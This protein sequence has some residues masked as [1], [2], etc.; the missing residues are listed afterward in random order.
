MLLGDPAGVAAGAARVVGVRLDPRA[1]R[2]CA[3]EMAARAEDSGA[4]REG[5]A[6]P[7]HVAHV[8]AAVAVAETDPQRSVLAH[9]RIDVVAVAHASIADRIVGLRVE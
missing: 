4:A 5:Q 2:E 9:E 7:G 8:A 3:V 1:E 6:S